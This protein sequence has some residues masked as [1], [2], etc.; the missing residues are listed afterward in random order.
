LQ[1]IYGYIFQKAFFDIIC[2]ISLL[3]FRKWER[4][5]LQDQEAEGNQ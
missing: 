3:F 4:R 5:A 2:D 1:K